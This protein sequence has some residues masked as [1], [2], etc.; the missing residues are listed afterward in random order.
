ME[1]AMKKPA[2]NYRTMFGLQEPQHHIHVQAKFMEGLGW[3]LL[4]VNCPDKENL[5]A[6][7][8]TSKK[9][10]EAYALCKDYTLTQDQQ[11]SLFTDKTL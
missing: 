3:Y 9:A 1:I 11:L 5:I 4:W 8:F 7:H 2:I 6:T 10:A